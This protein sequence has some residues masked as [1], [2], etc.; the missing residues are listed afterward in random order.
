MSRILIVDDNVDAADS[1]AMLLSIGGHSVETVYSGEA[2]MEAAGRLLPA[3][4]IIDLGMPKV[5]GLEVARHVRKQEW[6]K[7]PV[8]VALTGWGQD[9][10]RKGSRE[11]G[12]DHHL[13]KPVD[14]EALEDLIR[15]AGS[16]SA[17]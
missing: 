17:G 13:V 4:M 7:A 12:F 2:A 15:R 11:A 14:S 5:S 10:D 9:A 3:F 16:D 8:L 6:G 1:L